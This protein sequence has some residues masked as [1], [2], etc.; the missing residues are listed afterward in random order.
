VLEISHVLPT[1]KDVSS[2]AGLTRRAADRAERGLSSR[3]L[4]SHCLRVLRDVVAE[5]PRPDPGHGTVVTMPEF[6]LCPKEIC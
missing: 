5:T 2:A 4:Q 3:R 1:T 6:H